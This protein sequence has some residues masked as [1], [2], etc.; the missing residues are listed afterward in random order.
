VAK[1]FEDIKQSFSSAKVMNQLPFILFLFII[2]VAYIYFNHLAENRVREIGKV[3]SELKELRSE[4]LEAKNDLEKRSMQTQVA[5]IVD[6]FGLHELTTPPKKISI[7]A[8]Q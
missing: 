5:S 8:K 6:T 4:Y 7:H 1:P 3:K 2:C